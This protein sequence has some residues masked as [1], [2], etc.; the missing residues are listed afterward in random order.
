[1]LRKEYLNSIDETENTINLE[2]VVQQLIL[3]T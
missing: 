3:T 1:M 2:W